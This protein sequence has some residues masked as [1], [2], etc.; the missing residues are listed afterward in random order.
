MEVKVAME[1]PIT[2]IVGTESD[3]DVTGKRNDNLRMNDKA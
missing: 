2:G 3:S 1:E